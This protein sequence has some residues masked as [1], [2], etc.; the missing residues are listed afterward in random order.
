ML[1]GR[2]AGVQPWLAGGGRV[3][4]GRRRGHG[5]RAVYGPRR[6]RA[7]GG[8]ERRG[9]CRVSG[10]AR[11]G[12]RGG[13]AGAC[14]GAVD[15]PGHRR[16]VLAPGGA[17]VQVRRV[18]LRVCLG[19]GAAVRAA[20]GRGGALSTRSGSPTDRPGCFCFC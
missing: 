11:R 14:G 18:V 4:P 1:G 13:C 10:V 8:G 20:L 15:T 19:D 3:E 16:G 2:H 17:A 6:E 5:V 7:A 12:R 9:A